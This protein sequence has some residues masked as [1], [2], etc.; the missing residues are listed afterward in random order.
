MN[1]NKVNSNSADKCILCFVKTEVY[2]MDLMLTNNTGY[3]SV[4]YLLKTGAK[5]IDELH[6]S[7]NF[8]SFKK[9]PIATYRHI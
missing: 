5:I 2:F 4:V 7:H 8:G 1:N 9:D 3:F 6:F